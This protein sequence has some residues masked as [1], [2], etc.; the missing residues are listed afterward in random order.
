LTARQ[1]RGEN[2]PAGAPSQQ[3]TFLTK[4]VPGAALEVFPWQG[5]L[6]KS[7]VLDMSVW[8]VRTR[9][10]GEDLA[11]ETGHPGLLLDDVLRQKGRT[12]EEAR[13]SLLPVLI[14]GVVQ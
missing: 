12:P 5:L 6:I 8:V 3:D 9:Q 13:A 7:K 14:T 10:D 1:H 2:P 4:H 11:K